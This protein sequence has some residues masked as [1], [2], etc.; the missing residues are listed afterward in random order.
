[1]IKSSRVL[2]L[3]NW[4]I[5]DAM[6]SNSVTKRLTAN[7]K[8]KKE[9][10]G[11]KF[12]EDHAAIVIWSIRK[13]SKTISSQPNDTSLIGNLI[14]KRVEE[15]T[16][17]EAPELGVGSANFTLATTLRYKRKRLEL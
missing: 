7:D 17:E 13:G 9:M 1:M 4:D 14:V 11:A 2:L 16:S 10:K 3:P 8:E 5:V 15:T 12:S 6:V